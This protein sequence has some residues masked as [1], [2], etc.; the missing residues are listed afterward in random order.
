MSNHD[1]QKRKPNVERQQ[2]ETIEHDRKSEDEGSSCTLVATVV[3][4]STEAMAYSSSVASD[5]KKQKQK[6][7]KASRKLRTGIELLKQ[8]TELLDEETKS[9]ANAL[10]SAAHAKRE[11]KQDLAQRKRALAHQDALLEVLVDYVLSF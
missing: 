2:E 5:L 10:E 8:E 6:L 9:L 4:A 3:A 7:R 11:L 1:R